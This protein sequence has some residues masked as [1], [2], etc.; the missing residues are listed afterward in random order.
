VY[1]GSAMGPGGFKARV[2]RHLRSEK[3]LKWHLDYISSLFLPFALHCEPA[4]VSLECEWSAKLAD[5]GGL[6]VAP[7]FGSSDCLCASHLLFFR[8]EEHSPDSIADMLACCL[9]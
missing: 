3:K 7:R 8:R 6:V 4:S 1:L 5:R 2:G 9:S